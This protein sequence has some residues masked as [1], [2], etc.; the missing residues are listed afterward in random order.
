[1]RFDGDLTDAWRANLWLRTAVRVLWRLEQFEALDDDAL[2]AAVKKIDW[3][4]FVAP[5]V[6]S[7]SP[8]RRASRRSTTRASSSSA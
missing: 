2:Y 8:R 6:R 3:T 1:M 5:E 7:S 4:R